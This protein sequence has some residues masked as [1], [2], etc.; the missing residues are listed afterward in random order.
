MALWSTINCYV[1]SFI[2]Y[3]NIIGKG[4]RRITAHV[5]P[6]VYVYALRYHWL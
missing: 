4:V 3:L 1:Q 5:I 2:S 6:F